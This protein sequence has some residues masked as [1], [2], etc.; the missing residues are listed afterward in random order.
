MVTGWEEI[1]EEET[2]IIEHEM[3]ES[4]K[5]LIKTSDGKK[6]KKLKKQKKN[7]EETQQD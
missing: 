1:D 5:A 6:K 7:K 3:A 4:A 2:L